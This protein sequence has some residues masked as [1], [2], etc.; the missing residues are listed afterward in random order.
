VLRHNGGMKIDP[1]PGASSAK[2]AL[3]LSGGGA[4]AAYQAGVLRAI[5]EILPKRA[6]NPFPIIC[7]TSAG[8]LNAAALATHASRF[9]L[10]VH[11][12][13]L[14]W[15]SFHT[16][17]VFHT[18]FPSLLMRGGRWLGALLVGGLHTKRSISLLN[19]TPLAGLLE[20]ML[21]FDRISLAIERG[22]LHAV[23][24]T[25]SGYS[26]G[27]SVSFFEAARGVQA[28]RRTRR[29]GVR[30]RLGVPHLMASSAIPILF[31]AVRLNRE[32]FGDGSIRQ[33]SPLSPALHLGADRVLVVGVSGG[34]KAADTL[35]GPQPY[36]STGK[37]LGHLLNAAFL[38]GLELDVARLERTNRIA[39]LLSPEQRAESDLGLRH[40]DLFKLLPS[41]PLDE[42]ASQHAD[43]LPRSMRLLLRSN[44]RDQSNGSTL[45]SYLLFERGF[46]RALIDL[47]YQDAMRVRSELACFLGYGPLPDSAPQTESLG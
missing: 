38:D 34:A 18:D 28:W 26:S 33:L 39:A 30:A 40:I 47:G 16:S 10:G 15:R 25:C 3:V 19:N 35:G 17:Q 21:R 2:V 43:E 23:S 32:Y 24:V 13:E 37:V 20:R 29:V 9:Q 31:P 1:K 4:H 46:C 11:G 12:L 27:Q 44:R 42:I 45:L 14:V 8:A 5:V 22:D 6:P 36:P 41:R 7:G